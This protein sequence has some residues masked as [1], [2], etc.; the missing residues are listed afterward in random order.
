MIKKSIRHK[1][2][3]AGFLGDKHIYPDYPL[4]RQNARENRIDMT[5]AEKAIWSQ[6]RNQKLGVRFR[7]QHIIGD[8]IVDFICL[9]KHLII[10]VDG[11]Y[12]FTEEQKKED[13][14]RTQYL[15]KFGFRILRFTNAEVVADTENVVHK[16]KI[17]LET[18]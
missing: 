17:Q 5:D 4:L 16:I 2:N 1:P 7:R 9:E 18:N 6:L 10:E 11:R 3:S 12:H 14:I 8:Y 13:E 15:S